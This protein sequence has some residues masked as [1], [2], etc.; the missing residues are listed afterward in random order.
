MNS[1]MALIV[2]IDDER[3]EIELDAPRDRHGEMRREIDLNGK[4]VALFERK[5]S[6]GGGM[7]GGG[8]MLNEVAVQEAGKEVFDDLGVP[9]QPYETGYYTADAVEATTRNLFSTW[10]ISGLH[11]ASHESN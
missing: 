1:T 6:I 8:M 10:Q 11:R 3:F 5:L 2:N 7:W 9:T 4:K